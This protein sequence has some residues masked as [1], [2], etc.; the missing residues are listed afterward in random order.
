MAEAINRL[1]V[2]IGSPSDC[3]QERAIVRDLIPDANI[4]LKTLGIPIEFSFVWLGRR[5]FSGYR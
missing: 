5:C 4:D 3:K 2:F 1:T